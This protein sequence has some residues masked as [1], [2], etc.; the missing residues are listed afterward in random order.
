MNHID[1]VFKTEFVQQQY[2]EII[3]TD[4]ESVTQTD[5]VIKLI[6]MNELL[7]S[8][9]AGTQMNDVIETPPQEKTRPRKI[10][11]KSGKPPRKTNKKTKV[12]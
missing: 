2:N 1:I 3:T 5:D 8:T 12:C 7:P 10:R 11:A 4:D 9:S 6:V